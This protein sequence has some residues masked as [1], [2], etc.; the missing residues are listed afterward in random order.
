M[1][2][3]ALIPSERKQ[4]TTCVKQICAELWKII[5]I[6]KSMQAPEKLYLGSS[7]RE[8]RERLKKHKLDIKNGR[9]VAVA[10]QFMDTRSEVSDFVSRPFTRVR[11]RCRWVLRQLQLVLVTNERSLN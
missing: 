1:W 7:C 9:E 5:M 2:I 4:I 6:K 11:S 8:A 3:V 10:D